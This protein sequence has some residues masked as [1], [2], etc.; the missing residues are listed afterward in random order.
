MAVS[1]GPDVVTDGLVLAVDAT[2]TKS[3]RGEPTT[4]L[5]T[6]PEFATTSNWSLATNGGGTFSVSNNVGKITMGTAG[7]YNYLYQTISIAIPQNTTSTWSV[8]FVN[9]R[10]G[11]FAIRLV[12][13][14]G[15]AVP[16]QP[17]QTVVLD[18][19]GGTRRISVSA[20]YTTGTTTS[21]RLDILSG[22]YYSGLSNGDVEFRQ[23]QFETKPYAT[24]FVSGS[25]GTTV[26]TGGGLVDL[27]GNNDHFELVNGVSYD[28][29]NNG[30]LLFDG[31]DDKVY[32]NAVATYGNNT[33]WEIWAN[34][35]SSVNNFNMIMGRYLPYFAMRST[36]SLF[37]SNNISG[38]Q[39]NLTSTTAFI[40]NNTWYHFVFTTQ[41][42]GTN[43]TMSMYINGVFDTSRTDL[44][45]QGNYANYKLTLGDWRNDII[46]A[47]FSGKIYGLKVY[48]RTLSPQ[49]ILQNFNST[50]SRFGV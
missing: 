48:S 34:R 44:G 41:Y 26:A 7:S 15:A 9:N 31:I 46:D 40:Q 19:T 47:P 24:P 10:V 25:R 42:D 39:R 18:G 50:R 35:N 23:A 43:T 13:F 3:F 36:N 14:D 4:N 28:G 49:E 21:V 37:F 20:T 38:T 6:N 16:A 11:N 12:L 29:S 2:N 1:G 30:V 8:T 17:M 27:S 22:A 32:S 45:S 5:V 33:T